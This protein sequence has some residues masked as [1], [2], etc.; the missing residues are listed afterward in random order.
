MLIQVFMRRVYGAPNIYPANDAAQALALLAGKKT[1][2]HSDLQIAR[3]RLGMQVEQVADPEA[4]L[5]L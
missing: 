3:E 4:E 5:K 1:L 2:S